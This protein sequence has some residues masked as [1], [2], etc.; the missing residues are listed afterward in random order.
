MQKRRALTGY[1]ARALEADDI[2]GEVGTVKP[3]AHRQPVAQTESGGD[4][5]GHPRRGGSG[6]G[7]HRRASTRARTGER[8]DCLV[9][10]QVVGAEVVAP[11]RH[12]VRLVH[13]EQ[14]NLARCQRV[15]KR[16]RRK[17]LGSGEHKFC[18]ATGDR[19]QGSRVVPLLHPGRQHRR[20]HACLLQALVLIGHQCD[21]W[22]HD[23]DQLLA[24]QGGKL[25]AE[26]LASAGRHHN[27]AVASL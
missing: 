22:T 18:L 3:G 6:C 9:Q 15:A 17:P 12:A 2:E 23:H 19:A 20:A 25:I 13:D 1:R 26:R 10:T 5:L 27:Q 21:Q 8:L 11:L 16:T 14:P 4:L 24:G 7:H